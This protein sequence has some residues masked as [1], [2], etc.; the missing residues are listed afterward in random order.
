MQTGMSLSSAG[1][2]RSSIGKIIADTQDEEVL[3]AYYQI[4]LSLLRVQDRTQEIVAYSADS[5]PLTDQQLRLAVAE[6]SD[7]IEKGR[8]ISH[9]NAKKQ[10]ESW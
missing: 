4:L 8:F 1:E 3:K 7:R 6:A 2:L 5:E 10:A 9:E